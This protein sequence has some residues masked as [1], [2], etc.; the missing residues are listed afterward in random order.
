MSNQEAAQQGQSDECSGGGVCHG[1]GLLIS[2]GLIK[3]IATAVEFV[4][5]IKVQDVYTD[6][7]KYRV[8]E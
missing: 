5:E 6:W 7:S 8:A 4:E 3:L 1:S 2:G